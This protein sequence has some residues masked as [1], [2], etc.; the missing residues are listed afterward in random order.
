[1]S[2]FRRKL[3]NLP[4]Y[5][6]ISADVNNIPHGLAIFFPAKERPEFRVPISNKAFC[7]P[8]FIPVVRPAP[9]TKPAATLPTIFPYKFGKTITSNCCGLLTNCIHVL[10][11]II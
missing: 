1:M 11:I 3:I 5:S 6:N 4:K 2:K 8:K 9:P 7:G 10:S